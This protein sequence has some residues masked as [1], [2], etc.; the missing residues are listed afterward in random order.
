MIFEALIRDA[1]TPSR[2]KAVPVRSFTRKRPF[3]DAREACLERL[4]REV[5]A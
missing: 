4:R 3:H 1:L 5:G 2:S